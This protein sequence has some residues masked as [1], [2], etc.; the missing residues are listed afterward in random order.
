MSRKACESTAQSDNKITLAVIK[1]TMG[2]LMYELS[3]MKFKDPNK[4]SKDE[5]LAD[6]DDLHSRMAEAFRNLEE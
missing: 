6:F 4:M 2:K 1:D 3:S 5:I